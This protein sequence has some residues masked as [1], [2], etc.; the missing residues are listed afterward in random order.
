MQHEAPP[1]SFARQPHAVVIGSGFGGL[2]AAVRLGAR[3]YRVTVLEQ[4]DVPGGRA[5]VH[6]QDGFV[7]D[8]GPTIIT[9]PF[10]LEELWALCGR[11][12]ADD[13]ALVPMD[14]FYRIRF[15][16]GSEFTYS[17]DAEA[18]RR[19]VARFSPGDVEGYERFMRDSE[20]I[21]RVGFEQLGDAAFDSPM[22]ML[23]VAPDLLRLGGLRSVHA[24]VS[25]RIKDERLRAVFGYHPLLIGGSPFR[26]S[27]IY[28]LIAY[29]ERRWGVHFAM[30]GTGRLV[31]G[32]VGLIRGQG[33]T[34]RCGA[35]AAKIDVVDGAAAGVRLEDGERLAA[36]IVVSNAD[37]AW[38][39]SKLLPPEARRRWTD[40]RIAKAAYSMGLFVWYFGVR[41][42][43]EDV[44]H[45]TILMGPR[46][47]GLLDDVFRSKTLA[48][49]FSLY[50]HRPTATDPSLAPPGCDAFYVLSPVPNLQGGQD[51]PR[52]AEAYRQAIARS[53]SETLLPD[54]E[55]EI[56]TSRVT[57]PADF[58]ADF[59]SLHGAGFGLEPILSQSAWF[60]PHNR[61]E[62]VRNLFLVGAGTHPGAGLPGVLSSSRVLDK[63]APDAS[64]FA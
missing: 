16:D 53:L 47:R 33:G 48:E 21:Y 40:R 28:C 51:W 46:Y 37:S 8:A 35:R 61:S 4:L 26:A 3:G 31:D 9:A 30:G 29:L 56:I 39:Y 27:A 41:R 10:L 17:G 52:C 1:R 50:L 22:D 11:R 57:T 34:V 20:A 15:Q 5:R 24:A 63:V 36:D 42:R 13:V 2:A 55:A 6:R 44:A 64:V 19:E 38:T 58:A 25:R 49:D 18:M 43:Y 45:H 59:S 60:R 62:D 32:L 7:F 14:P 23:R 54:L 12:L